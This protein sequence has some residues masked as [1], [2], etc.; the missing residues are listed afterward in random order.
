MTILYSTARSANGRKVL[1]L[2]QYLALD[3]EVRTFERSMSTAVRGKRKPTRRS[4]AQ[5]MGEDPHARGRRIRAFGVERDPG[6]LCGTG[7]DPCSARGRAKET[8]PCSEVALLGILSLA[9]DA[10][11]DSRPAGITA[12]CR[13]HAAV[14]HVPLERRRIDSSVGVSRVG[15]RLPRVRRGGRLVDRGFLRRWHDH[16][17]RCCSIPS[18]RLSGDLGVDAA[19]AVPACMG[20]HSGG[21][22]DLGRSHEVHELAGPCCSH[23]ADLLLF[24]SAQCRAGAPPLIPSERPR[25]PASPAGCWSRRGDSRRSARPGFQSPATAPYR[26]ASGRRSCTARSGPRPPRRALHGGV[27]R[28]S[29]AAA[30]RRAQ[31]RDL[32]AHD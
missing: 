15:A 31:G 11:S 25:R 16:V 21:S 18:A 2:A 6:V 8:C 12:S 29:P 30:H 13:H 7:E 27:G 17:L 4:T 20:G 10:R 19:N 28:R 3:V 5:P 24:G 1:A 23:H 14:R 9:T 26:G 32:D 22:V